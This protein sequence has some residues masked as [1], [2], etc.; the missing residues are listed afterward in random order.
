VRVAIALPSAEKLKP[1]MNVEAIFEVGNLENAILV[2]NAAVVRQA[3]GAG[4]YVVG[5]DRQPI[6]QPIQ[7]GITTGGQTEVR[8]G[9]QG[10]EQILISPP[11]TPKPG[12]L[13]FPPR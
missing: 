10:T 13:S 7:I 6:F 5:S 3:Q 11:T 8:S 1:G 4:V 9:L 12:G 2:P